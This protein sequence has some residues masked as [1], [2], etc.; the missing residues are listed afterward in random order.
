MYRKINSHQTLVARNNSNTH[1][2]AYYAV[3]KQHAN[4]HSNWE[5]LGIWCMNYKGPMTLGLNYDDGDF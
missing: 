1:R 4:C 3:Q 2:T 5:C